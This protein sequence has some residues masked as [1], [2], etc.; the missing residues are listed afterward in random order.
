MLNV[1]R[2]DEGVSRWMLQKLS[3]VSNFGENYSATELVGD[4]IQG[5][6]FVLFPY[7]GFI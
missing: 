4:L 5:R 6:G 2:Y 3:L 7:D 1:V